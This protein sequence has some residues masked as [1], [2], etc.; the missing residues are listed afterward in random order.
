MARKMAQ[1]LREPTGVLEEDLSS[2]ISSSQLPITPASEGAISRPQ[3]VH[4][5]SHTI[6]NK[7]F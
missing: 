4:T 1:Q 7:Y 3:H 5:L 6:K 2:I